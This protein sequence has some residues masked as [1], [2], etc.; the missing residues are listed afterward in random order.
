MQLERNLKVSK[1]GEKVGLIMEWSFSTVIVLAM[2]ESN[3][4]ISS[5]FRGTM[6]SKLEVYSQ[7]SYQPAFSNM[8]GLYLPRFVSQAASVAVPHEN[9][10]MNQEKRRQRIEATKDSVWE[11]VN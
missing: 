5:K 9:N 7:P 4:K 1:E 8:Q 6:I 2:L 11:E 3:G 10:R